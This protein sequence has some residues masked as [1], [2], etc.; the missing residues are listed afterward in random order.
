METLLRGYQVSDPT[1]FYLSCLLILAVFARFGRLVSVRN[2]DLALL[3]SIAPG[4][5]LVRQPR[6]ELGYVWLFVVSALLLV[7]ALCDNLMPRR[8]QIRPNLNAAGLTFL[9]A[10]AFVF[11]MAR[12]MT[13]QPHQGTIETVKR[14]ERML[15]GHQT[16]V[17]AKLPEPTEEPT[18]VPAGPAS[19]LLSAPVVQISRVT[20][21]QPLNVGL[22]AVRGL[23]VMAH[24]AVIAALIFVGWKLFNDF[25]T[26]IATATLYMLLPCTAYDVGRAMHVLP[27]ALIVWAIGAYRRPVL[28]GMLMGLA[29]GML[30][31]P[32]LLLPLWCVFYGWRGTLRF[33]AAVALVAGSLVSVQFLIAPDSSLREV[34]SYLELEQLTFRMSDGDFPGFWN[35]HDVAWRMPVFVT[36]LVMVSALVLWPRKKHLGHLIAHS[37]ATI[38]GIQFW[39]LQAG[40]V[41]V[42]WYLP[43][44]LLMVYRP[45]LTQHAAPEMAPLLSRKTVRQ[46]EPQAPTLAT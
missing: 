19:Q 21:S 33:L 39:Y 18:E 8:P 6:P 4:L 32:I 29:C 13:E 15:D 34:L 22:V 7:R 2:L 45:T 10:S 43:L 44:V 27:A 28:T 24:L 42:L 23:V 17:S 41:Y 38:L 3:L 9:C 26:G 30:F 35:S 1:W 37:A 31:F 16:R 20:S 14:A 12:V 36:Y 46:A 5:L 25:E 11:L 40:G